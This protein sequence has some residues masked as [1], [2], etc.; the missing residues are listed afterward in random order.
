M[1]KRNVILIVIVFLIILSSLGAAFYISLNNNKPIE[2]EA[3]VKL[4]GN[5]YII[6]EDSTGEEY[7]I[8]TTEGYNVGDRIDFVIKDIESDSNPKTGTIVKI[9]TI[10]KSIS[11]SITDANSTDEDATK[12][13]N[14]DVNGY[15]KKENVIIDED[16]IDTDSNETISTSTTDKDI[17]TY[18]TNLD[19]NLDNYNQDKSIGKKIKEGFITVVD[20]LFYDGKIK[21]KTFDDLSNT[22][23]IKVLQIAFSIDEKMDKYFPGYKEE[24]S[25]TS[26]SIYTSVK[27]KATELYLNITTNI[28]ENDPTTCQTAKEGLSDLKESFSLTWDFIKDTGT[29]GLKKLKEWYEI[30][31][32]V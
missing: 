18:F 13:N 10:S 27:S 28:C 29:T 12:N 15:V 17:V 23:K 4:I 31:K 2:V 11:F 19:N 16:N 3:T 21:G 26:K 22:T 14:V 9:D 5:N 7:S 32:T 6:V 25:T 20:F 8:E 30:W 1:N 24:I